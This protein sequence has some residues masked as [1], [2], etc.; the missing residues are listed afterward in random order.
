MF[1]RANVETRLCATSSADSYNNTDALKNWLNVIF[2]II[3]VQSY[4][5][6]DNDV[7]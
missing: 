7:V 6:L 3:I 1:T 2:F 4:V 5:K